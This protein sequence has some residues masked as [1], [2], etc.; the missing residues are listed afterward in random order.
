[1]AN[2][3]YKVIKIINHGEWLRSC[4]VFV[5]RSQII[6]NN[7]NDKL[8]LVNEM[9][10]IGIKD[11]SE[12]IIKIE[13]VDADGEIIS[14]VD[15]C[16]YQGMNVTKQA[17][18][19]G[20]KLFMI[21]DGTENVNI[22][23][24]SITYADKTVW[25]NDYLLR[26]IKVDNP[27]RI[28][29]SD[30]VYDVVSTR[31]NEYHITP[32]FWPY[33]FPGGW[34]CTCAQLNDEDNMTC[35]LC[36]SS[37]F[38]ILDNLN[39]DDIIEYKE[40]VEREI[41]LRLEREAEERRLAAEREAEE[42]RLAAERE[43]EEKRRAE[44]EARLAAERE[45]EERRL[46]AEREEEEKRLAAERAIEEAKRLEAEKKAAEERARLELLMAKKE[47]VRQYNM[48]QTKKSV[49]KNFVVAVVVILVLALG[50]GAFELY[51][52]IR[53]NDRY[54]SAKKYIANYEYN[55][56]IRVYKS[57]GNYKDSAEQVI[58]TKY[59]YADYL[60]VI[61]KFDE[62][63][64][65]YNELGNYKDSASRIRQ[66][67]VKWGDYARENNQFADAFSYYESAGDLVDS[68]A[69]YDTSY[70]YGLNLMKNG[71][72]SEAIKAFES[73]GERAGIKTKIAECYYQMGKTNLSQGRFDDAIKCFENS[74]YTEDTN[75]LNKQAYY[76]K[77]NKML[78]A[79]NVEEAYNCYLN[80]G[81]YEDAKE[82]LADLSY[83]LGVIRLKEGNYN[84]AILLLQNAA[85]TSEVTDMYNEALYQ[86]AEFMLSQGVN[87]SILDI[88]K[89]LPADY[90]NCKD[91]IKLIEQY[92][93]YVGTYRTDSEDASVKSREVRMTIINDEV[94]LR[95]DGEILDN[96]TL[97]S[98]SARI[99]KDSLK[100]TDD[101][102]NTV[103]YKK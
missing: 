99:T 8:F 86:Y 14:A 100:F 40:R 56:A 85:D 78:T 26:G 66:T 55:E 32:K 67:Y 79:G 22:I 53:I 33:E 73:S 16:A 93:Q 38:W 6:L 68:E 89:K 88:Y 39:R 13:C 72:Y 47:A 29:P 92:I 94:Q 71:S 57:L 102:G 69:L 19:G 65:L 90:E 87:Q 101:K 96:K 9:A 2:E 41:K 7:E 20:N 45:A 95:V 44:E 51:Q 31:C 49:R 60:V 62:A 17:L 74:Y 91:R 30:S 98:K 52:F 64:E 46:A 23:I 37:K 4:P 43:A 97:E 21:A 58:E 48:Q 75:E 59:Q 42:R 34:R 24:K 77:G 84:A 76:L 63:I 35:S 103:T 81:D 18:F 10:N 80:A 36:G 3:K 12:V 54:E 27:V 28:D 11:I 15:N 5:V 1:M 25:S 50:F 61:S 70:E 82:K 83:E